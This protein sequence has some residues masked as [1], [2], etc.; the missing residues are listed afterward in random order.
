MKTK[1]AYSNLVIGILLLAA[2]LM[3]IRTYAQPDYTF[4]NPVLISGTDRQVGAVYLFSNVK[5]GVDAMLTINSISAGITVSELDGASGYPEALQ[6]TLVAS[7]FTNGYLEMFIEFVHA[8][9]STPYLQ[10]EVPVTC[11]DVDGW[12]DHDGLGNPLHEFDQVDVGGGYVDYQLT[13][14]ELVVAQEGNWFNGKNT[15][16]IDY[17]GRDTSARQ[18][19]FTV[20][21]GNISSCI[22]RVGVDNQ[23]SIAGNRLRSVYF[24]KFSYPNSILARSSLLTFRGI[25]KNG[26]IDLQWKLATEHSLKTIFVEK[27]DGSGFSTIAQVDPSEN[28]DGTFNFKDSDASAEKIYYR[29]KLVSL[30]G[31]VKYS[32]V[33]FFTADAANKGFKIY[34]SVVQSGATIQITSVKNSQAVFQLVDYSGRVL[35]KQQVHVH[36][37]TNNIPITNLHRLQS[38]HYIAL[39]EVDNKIFTQKILKH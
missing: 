28:V 8:G 30:N 16:G 36:E 6:P 24:K 14:G 33:L 31:T 2:F 32:N 38:G 7:P 18:V 37:G 35:M 12:A 1:H 26:T 17:P 11:I 25:E 21:N 5:P 13:G 20:V 23:S 39:M 22:I 4:Q 19:M 3:S 15:G 10:T 29:L 34:P 27:G 9:T